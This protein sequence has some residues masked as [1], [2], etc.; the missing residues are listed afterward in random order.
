MSTPYTKLEDFPPYLAD[1]VRALIGQHRIENMI[2]RRDNLQA[3]TFYHGAQK[4]VLLEVAKDCFK[5]YRM[6]EGEGRTEGYKIPYAKFT[7]EEI[8]SI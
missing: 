5:L 4:F 2:D 3:S 8:F 1:E 7:R 6:T